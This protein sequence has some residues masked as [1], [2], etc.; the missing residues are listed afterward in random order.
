[1]GLNGP[2]MRRLPTWLLGVSCLGSVDYTYSSDIEF[3][4]ETSCHFWFCGSAGDA[5]LDLVVSHSSRD[6]T[7]PRSRSHAFLFASSLGP[8]HAASARVVD[9]GPWAL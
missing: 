1:M 2:G 5:M 4:C 3:W 9:L 6:S 7:C 8:R